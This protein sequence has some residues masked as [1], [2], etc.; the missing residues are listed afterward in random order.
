METIDQI[1]QVANIIE[2]ASQYTNLHKRGNKH[3]GLCPFHPDK[4][5]SFTVDEERQLYHC[6]GCGAGGDI[7]TLVMEKESLSF[8]ES[9]RYLAEKYNI[10][11]PEQKKFSPQLAKLEEKLYKVC[12]DTLAFFKKNLFNTEEGKKAIDYLKK[13]NIS[14]DA[15]QELKIGYALN[16]WDSLINYFQR[17]NISPGLLEKAGLVLQ[18]QKK[19]GHYDRFRGRIIFP[20]FKDTGK[21]VAFGGRTI[22]D[23]D[24]KYLNSPDTPIYTKGHLLY[25]LNH[26]KKSIRETGEVILVEGYTDFLIPFQEGVTNIAA[27]LGTSLTPQQVML[28]KRFAPR[29]TISFDGDVP[30]RKATLR[31][32]SLGFE[33]GIQTKVMILPSGHDPDNFIKKYGVEKFK[34]L[35]EK[36]IPGLKFL[37]DSQLQES[38]M[39]IPEEKAKVL[40]NIVR[41]IEKIPDSL[42]RSEYLKKT[43]EYLSIEES[44]LRSVIK[45][46]A[47]KKK[48]DIELDNFFPAEK[49]LIQILFQDSNIASSVL[50]EVREEDFMGLKSEPI[51]SFLSGIFKKKKKPN[52]HE[53]KENIDPKLFS[54]L[55]KILLEREQGTS[56]REAEDCLIAL[57]QLSL[58]KQSR[59]LKDQ[60][61]KFERNGEKDKVR[62]LL[63]KR[64]EITK[65]LSLLSQRNQ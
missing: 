60:I 21:V 61:A 37:L 4:N 43:S 47:S 54:S 41:E 5:P 52:L 25:G 32:I 57:R 51:F 64:H 62:T 34:A 39:D 45:K 49:R 36:S 65:K 23:A 12:E 59:E 56:V 28:A 7:F 17:K 6:F 15:I 55:S 10:K 35:K 20:I 53:F 9:M 11:L 31:A 44:A 50:K 14:E 38:K 18:R 19:E 22:F 58:E 40:R 30:G 29:M 48:V 26:T 8:P 46:G 24:P 16:T 1:K 3:I 27:S 63:N 42:V 13:R 2:I 33:N